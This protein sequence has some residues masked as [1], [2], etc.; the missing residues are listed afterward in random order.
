M[1]VVAVVMVDVPSIPVVDLDVVRSGTALAGFEK[2]L[3][4]QK[5]DTPLCA[6]VVH[7]FNGL[8]PTLMLEED[9]R[10]VTILFQIPTHGGADPL[11]GPV[12]HLPQHTLGGREFENLHVELPRSKAELDYSSDVTLTLRILGPPSGE[13]VDRRQCSIRLFGRRR[14]CPD[15]VQDVWHW[16]FLFLVFVCLC[17]SDTAGFGLTLPEQLLRNERRVLALHRLDGAG[18]PTFGHRC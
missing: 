4:T 7:E 9:D 10:V 8:L 15:S 5:K 3:E 16:L 2:R 1:G 6:A 13:T 17:T 14:L 18:A 11:L 12:H